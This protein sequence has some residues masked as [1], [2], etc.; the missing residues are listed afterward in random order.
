MPFFL[1]N[2]IPNYLQY[3]YISIDDRQSNL[4]SILRCFLISR[5]ILFH[6]FADKSYGGEERDNLKLLFRSIFFFL[7]E[8]SPSTPIY[9]LESKKTR[10]DEQING[11]EWAARRCFE[12]INVRAVSWTAN[13]FPYFVVT[14]GPWKS[15]ISFDV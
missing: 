3:R 11:R 10:L 15:A 4:Y 12:V 5:D 14:R 7:L 2:P 9:P 8:F 13:L 1:W 6:P